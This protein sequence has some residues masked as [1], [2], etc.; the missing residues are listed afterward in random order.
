MDNYRITLTLQER[1][2]LEQLVSMA[3]PAAWEPTHARK[4]LR[5]DERH[6]AACADPEIVLALGTSLRTIERHQD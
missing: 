6:G 4:L 1:N 3:K 2:G 5:A